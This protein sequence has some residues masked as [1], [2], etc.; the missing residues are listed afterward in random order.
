MVISGVHRVN[1]TNTDFIKVFI[2]VMDLSEA[3]VS[4]SIF[5]LLQASLF[6]FHFPSL[7]VSLSK[8]LPAFP[9]L[10]K[11]KD[12]TIHNC[13]LLCVEGRLETD[14]MI[15]LVCELKILGVYTWS[16][17]ATFGVSRIPLKNI[18]GLWE[19]NCCPNWRKTRKNRKN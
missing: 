2:D 17:T 12:N 11:K 8:V 3:F 9:L 16:L 18:L 15:A 5:K 4:F 14:Q 7:R 13:F 6:P 1:Y 19:I 10:V